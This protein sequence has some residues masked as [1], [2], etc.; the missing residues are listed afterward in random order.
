MKTEKTAKAGKKSAVKAAKGKAL[1]TENKEQTKAVITSNKDLK[2][3][4]P[5]SCEKGKNKEELLKKRKAFRQGVRAKIKSLIKAE[6]TALKASVKGD[7]T[8]KDVAEAKKARAA[9]EKEVLA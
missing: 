8:A 9:F 7:G 6:K 2:Y 3:I 1:D 5:A 4:Y